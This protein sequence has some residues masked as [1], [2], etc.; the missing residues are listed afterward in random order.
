MNTDTPDTAARGAG[1]SRRF[2]EAEIAS[3]N[4]AIGPGARV[5]D[6]SFA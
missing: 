4:T 3:A 6:L 5:R 1:C 2:S